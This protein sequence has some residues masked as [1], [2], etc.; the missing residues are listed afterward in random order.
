[1]V[2]AGGRPLL[3][4]LRSEY[5]SVKISLIINPAIDFFCGTSHAFLH[6]IAVFFR[7]MTSLQDELLCTYAALILHD[8]GAVPGLQP[9]AKLKTPRSFEEK[10]LKVEMFHPKRPNFRRASF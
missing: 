7:F 8:D 3:L 5:F 10:D 6:S 2:V 1:M 9:F 4:D